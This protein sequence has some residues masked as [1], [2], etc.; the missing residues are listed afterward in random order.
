[1]VITVN[2]LKLV[3]SEIF[4]NAENGGG[5]ATNNIIIDGMSNNLFDDVTQQDRVYGK[6]NE[7]KVFAAV[8]TTNSD[9]LM[10]AMAYVSKL[11]KDANIN[12]NLAQSNTWFDTRTTHA[13]KTKGIQ[14]ALDVP[15]R[16]D[17]NQM[18]P[19]F[20]SK[21]KLETNK[22]F[23][24]FIVRESDLVTDMLLNGKAEIF[25]AGID[26]MIVDLADLNNSTTL[27]G[28]DGIREILTNDFI[29]SDGTSSERVIVSF[30]EIMEYR[31][32][33][34][35]SKDINGINQITYQRDIEQYHP[36][37]FYKAKLHLVYKTGKDYF[38]LPSAYDALNWIDSPT[39]LLSVQKEQVPKFYSSQR[40]QQEIG[41]TGSMNF[42]ILNNV[43]KVIPLITDN[44]II[45]VELD[46]QTLGID[47]SQFNGTGKYTYFASG[48]VGIILN[49]KE[50]I[51]TFTNGQSV[52]LT[53]QN[54]AKVT[55]RDSA[56]NLIDAAK[57]SANLTAGTVQF[58][59]VSGLSQPLTITDRIEDLFLVRAV[60]ELVGYSIITTV[61]PL[62]N[63]YPIEGTIV[64][65]CALFGT[66]YANVSKPFD[67]Q[68]WTNVWSDALI[69]SSVT[70]QFDFNNYPIVVNN[71]NAVT[72][73]WAI[74][75]TSSTTYNLVSEQFGQ[76]VTGQ[77]V[78][79]DLEPI[80]PNTNQ[81]YFTLPTLGLGGGWSSGNVIRFNT[82]AAAAPFWVLQSISQ[83]E[84]T[85]PDF[86]FAIEVRGDIDAA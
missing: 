61:K 1:M 74:I 15:F 27:Y 32:S 20:D 50:T 33:F 49:D 56:G 16:L 45:P 70:A 75:F 79:T 19:L 66:L 2:D 59:D 84:A 42:Y 65:N 82:Y 80:N 17:N 11:P 26:G 44:E 69:G 48:D 25:V 60:E 46:S 55:V 12:V 58:V 63:A 64:S 68:T 7:R 76:I 52:T 35:V 9:K 86:D 53:R 30:V 43:N 4:S 47:L 38:G 77:S 6:V 85:D 83:G 39:K 67:Q 62:K 54:L 34:V 13:F 21:Y 36:R 14:S 18:I 40:I 8:R 71:L 3:E 51:G 73:R 10:S 22:Y 23:S 31:D 5:G 28:I 78:S 24:C 57:F 37:K 81:P 41:A 29:I 72:D